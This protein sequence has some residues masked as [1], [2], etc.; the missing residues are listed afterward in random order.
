MK[1]KIS[2]ILLL[3]VIIGAAVVFGFY[4]PNFKS[5]DT[6]QAPAGN[7][8]Q[9][10]IENNV[11]NDDVF[12]VSFNNGETLSFD[13][14]EGVVAGQA[15]AGGVSVIYFLDESVESDDPSDAMFLLMTL[16]AALDFNN[17]DL[18][19]VDVD[20]LDFLTLEEYVTN[21]REQ[22]LSDEAVVINDVEF[23]QTEE[24]LY[25]YFADENFPFV[26]VIDKEFLQGELANMVLQG[27]SIQ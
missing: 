2:L 25:R 26:L 27:V 9:N 1:G 15:D 21:F 19:N 17:M 18:D 11:Q 3:I 7:E 5:N 14:P 13:L 12:S 10:D 6:D 24:A 22:T 4:E 8:A 16:E 20:N 23:R